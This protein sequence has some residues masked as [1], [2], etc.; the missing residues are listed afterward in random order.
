MIYIKRA[1]NDI[2][3]DMK[4]KSKVLN[5]LRKSNYR[6]YGILARYKIWRYR[7]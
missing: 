7:K 5:I 6:L 1:T 2:Y 4:R 3:V